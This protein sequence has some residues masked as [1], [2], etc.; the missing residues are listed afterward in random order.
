[1]RRSLFVLLASSPGAVLAPGTAV[2]PVREILHGI[3]IPDACRW[4]ED[5]NRPDTRA[6]TGAR[7]R[8]TRSFLDRIPRAQLK[9]RLEPLRRAD[10]V[11]MPIVRSGRHV[12]R[13]RLARENRA[14]I[15]LRTGPAGEF[16]RSREAG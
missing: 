16:P 11:G 9:R 1:M 4:L 3:T 14:S 8:Y 5:Q 7:M 2:R 6:W 15:C 13:W 10:S 12:F